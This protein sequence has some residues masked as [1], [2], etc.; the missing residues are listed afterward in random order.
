MYMFRSHNQTAG[1]NHNT[2]V[3]NKSFENM[4]KLKYFGT[5]VPN[6]HFIH[7]EIKSRL[8]L[9]NA[10]YHA[11]QNILSSCLLPKIID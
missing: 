11:V 10:C 2:Q 1:Q 9:R 4:A 5:T 3:G 7:A 6:Q 8:N